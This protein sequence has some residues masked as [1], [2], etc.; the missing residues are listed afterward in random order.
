MTTGEPG[1]T[2]DPSYVR[3]RGLNGARK[4][5]GEPRVINLRDLTDARRI[6]VNRFVAAMRAEQARENGA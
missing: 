6:R 3:S 2:K 5:W 1:W 4:R